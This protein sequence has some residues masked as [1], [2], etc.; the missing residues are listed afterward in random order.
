MDHV[1]LTATKCELEVAE[2]G[3]RVPGNFIPQCMV[4][5]EYEKI[6]C[7]GSI[8]HCWCVNEIGEELV[9]TRRGPGEGRPICDKS[10]YMGNIADCAVS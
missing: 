3:P 8:G 6:Q 1:L 7:H 9:G 2:A 5:G 4:T 10:E